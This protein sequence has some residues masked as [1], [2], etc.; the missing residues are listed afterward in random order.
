MVSVPEVS[1]LPDQSPDAVQL[2]ASLLS[3]LRVVEPF[4]GTLVGS[5]DRLTVGIVGVSTETVTESSAVPPVP[6]HDK[7]KVLLS[8]SEFMV[9]DPEVFL[10][11]DQSPDAVQLSVS[12]LLQ[13]RV[14]EPS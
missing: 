6:V 9:S 11:P 13:L 14:V 4:C 1:L 12:L 10:E 7:L 8:V 3:Q 2:T 5:A